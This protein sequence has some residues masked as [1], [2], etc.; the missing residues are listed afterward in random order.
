[1]GATIGAESCFFPTVF[2]TVYYFRVNEEMR[3]GGLVFVNEINWKKRTEVSAKNMKENKTRS[4]L[5]G[6]N[7]H[8]EHHPKTCPQVTR[9]GSNRHKPSYTSKVLLKMK[10]AHMSIRKRILLLSHI[11]NAGKV[12]VMVTN[13]KSSPTPS[14]LSWHSLQTSRRIAAML[15]LVFTSL[16]YSF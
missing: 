3:L 14:P 7:Q 11:R 6:G 5:V 1:M 4:R 8:P 10:G 2:S 12:E 15:S 13:P 9:K 16:H